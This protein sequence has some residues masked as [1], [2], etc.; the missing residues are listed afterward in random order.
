V[1][2]KMTHSIHVC[3]VGFGCIRASNL[4]GWKLMVI[5]ASAFPV[6]RNFQDF[7]MH[8]IV[9]HFDDEDE[10]VRYISAFAFWRMEKT[11][12]SGG[13]AT[14]YSL[15]LVTQFMVWIQLCLGGC[16]SMPVSITMVVLADQ[17]CTV[18]NGVLWWHH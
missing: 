14:P 13:E 15:D 5:L 3:A 1:I 6:T 12:R 7:F 17:G 18:S 4:Q 11:I 10:S 9:Q 8:F 16:L 2:V